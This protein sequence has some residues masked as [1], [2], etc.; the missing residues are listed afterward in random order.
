LVAPLTGSF[1]AEGSVYP[2]VQALAFMR[3][4]NDKAT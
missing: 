1:L 2:A 4:A 3:A